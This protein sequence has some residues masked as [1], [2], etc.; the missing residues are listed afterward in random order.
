MPLINLMKLVS[1]KM[2]VGLNVR[3]FFPLLNTIID[4]DWNNKTYIE[5][6]QEMLQIFPTKPFHFLQ[7]F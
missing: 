6:S 5:L 7:I 3:N 1:G 2:V 4:L